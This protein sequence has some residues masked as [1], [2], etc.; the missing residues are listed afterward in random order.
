MGVTPRPHARVPHAGLVLPWLLPHLPGGPPLHL[1]ALARSR[2]ARDIPGA[3][4]LAL[5]G[6]V[7]AATHVF[8]DGFTRG[9]RD[10]G[11]ALAFLPAHGTEG[12]GRLWTSPPDL[13]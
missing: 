1:H 6:L 9:N 5:S 7:G 12:T 4:R 13:T 11:W 8:L 3:A 2:P 10:G